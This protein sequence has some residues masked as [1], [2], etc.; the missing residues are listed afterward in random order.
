MEKQ[1]EVR[2]SRIILIISIASTFLFSLCLTFCVCSCIRNQDMETLLVCIPI[3][4]GFI[5]LG[6]FLL[7]D[8]CRRKLVLYSGCFSYTPALGRTG[9]FSYSEIQS[10]V[11]K[12]EKYIIYGYDGARLA[13]F[14]INMPACSDALKYLLEKQVKI[15]PRAPF[16]FS[17][18]PG[19]IPDW[20]LNL[21][22][23]DKDAYIRSGYSSVSTRN[24]KRITRV[25]Q[26]AMVILCIL[27]IPLS[28][29]RMLTVYILV[30][31]SAY[32][33]FLLFYPKMSLETG[34][35]CDENHI[36][37]PMLPCII[38]MVF[39]LSFID[40]FQME[41]GIW[42]PMSAA[43][44]AIL[45]IPYLIVLCVRRIKEHPLKI[46]LAAGILFLLSFV[47]VPPVNYVTAGRPSHD[48][49]TVLS[50]EQ[51]RSSHMTHY[52]VVVIWREN[53]QKMGVSRKLYESVETGDFVRVCVRKSVFGVELWNV[54]S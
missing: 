36:P 47:M 16:F 27:A 42:L 31:L 11:P 10:V 3:F 22:L 8:S 52:E 40:L 12:G 35:N 4:G 50:K 53:V 5:L 7:L 19:K 6:V 32:F 54:H 20:S 17:P 49:V 14:E 45:L 1:V 44:T 29:K 46:L 18:L 28:T 2:E 33:Q 43:M 15:S 51:R 39:L 9:T 25:I 21:H 37:F 48:T 41:E 38:S 34:K 30:L 24:Q 26:S 23:T 13:V